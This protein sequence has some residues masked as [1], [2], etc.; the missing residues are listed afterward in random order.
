MATDWGYYD[1]F[2]E[3]NDKYLPYKGKGWNNL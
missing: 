2:E 3:V 1:K